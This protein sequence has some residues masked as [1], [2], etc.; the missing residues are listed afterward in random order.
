MKISRKH[1]RTARKLVLPLIAL[2]MMTMM[3]ALTSGASS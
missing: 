3:M 1:R 2:A